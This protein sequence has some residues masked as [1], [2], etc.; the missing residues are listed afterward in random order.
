LKYTND[1]ETAKDLTQEVLIKVITNLS[2]FKGKRAFKT[3][4]YRIVVNQFLQ[5]KRRLTEDQQ[6]SV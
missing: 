2:S 3:W 4:V 6:F 1:Q 5:T